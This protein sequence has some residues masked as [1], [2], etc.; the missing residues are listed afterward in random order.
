MEEN[1]ITEEGLERLKEELEYLE[2]HRRK[3]VAARI[4]KALEQGDL[5][6]NAEYAEAKEE[7]AFVEGKILEL[8]DVVKRAKVVKKKRGG[9]GAKVDV[10]S[11][12]LVLNGKEKKELTIV[13]STEA[14]P[15]KGKVSHESPIGKAFIGKQKGDSVE[16][17][18]PGGKQTFK[19]LEIK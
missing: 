12:V 1:F 19:V 5:S 17:I 8:K 2:T 9:K 6:E 10:G 7:Q 3:Q 18:T 11:T 15:L 14:D 16:V 13:G 4:K